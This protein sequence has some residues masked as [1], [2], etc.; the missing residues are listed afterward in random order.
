MLDLTCI[1]LLTDTCR[2]TASVI[3]TVFFVFCSY[4]Y[5]NSVFC[6]WCYWTSFVV[7]LFSPGIPGFSA[8]NPRS[9]QK[10]DRQQEN[11]T[12]AFQPALTLSPSLLSPFTVSTACPCLIPV[13]AV[14]VHSHRSVCPCLIPVTAVPVHSQRSVPVSFLSLLSL[15]TVS[16]LSVPV[17]F[18][19]LLSP[20]TVSTACP[21][22]IPVTAVPVHSQCW[23]STG[24]W[25][26]L[27]HWQS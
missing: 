10:E 1:S 19:S 26:L 2:I 23:V 12:V 16:A 27:F 4:C 20:F 3:W 11:G 18:L 15:F 8:R 14:S 17:S 9:W 7:A 25:N 22:L 21:C 13:T 24:N 5:L 6:S